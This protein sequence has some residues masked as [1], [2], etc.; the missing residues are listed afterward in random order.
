MAILLSHLSAIY[1][2]ADA[3][4]LATDIDRS[5]LASAERCRY[6]PED[7]GRLPRFARPFVHR[8]A[9]GM[10]IVAAGP[11]DLARFRYHN[12]V[13]EDWPM[14]GPFDAIFCRNVLI[15]LSREDQAKVIDRLARLLKVGGILCLGHSEV[16]RGANLPIRRIEVPSSYVR[17]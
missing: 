9:D 6:T 1:P 14:R 12:L 8:E 5:I 17:I 3:R 4:V 13:G 7:I 15:Y 2:D 10:F 16:A 11:R